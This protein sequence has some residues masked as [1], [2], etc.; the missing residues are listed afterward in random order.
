MTDEKIIQMF[1]DRREE[2]IKETEKRYGA[3]CFK[4]A[5]SVLQSR[6]DSEECLNDALLQA[7]NM[8][9]PTRPAHLKLF[10]AKIVRNLAISKYRSKYAKKRGQGEVAI[11]LDELEECIAGQSDVEAYFEISELQKS[12]NEFVRGLPERDG[13]IFIARY[14]YMYSTKEIA[15]K[16][17][18]SENNIRVMLSRMRERLRNWLQK[19]GY[20]I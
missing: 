19:E 3:Y 16:F 4:V 18:V 13:N 17:H 6:E 7:W 20:V 15:R 8:I 11:V 5:Q 2:A 1:W 9:P 14:F 10:L 12:V